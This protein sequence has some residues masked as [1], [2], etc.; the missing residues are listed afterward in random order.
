[1][2]PLAVPRS[3]DRRA[4][5]VVA[6]VDNDV[7]PLDRF[8]GAKIVDLEKGKQVNARKAQHNRSGIYLEFVFNVRGI[9]RVLAQLADEVV[10]AN[11]GFVVAGPVCPR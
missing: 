10:E 4:P 9:E 6:A 7:H 11:Q 5:F 1:M 3:G 8:F 2:K